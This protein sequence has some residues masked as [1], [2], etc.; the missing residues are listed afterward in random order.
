MSTAETAAHTL[1]SLPGISSQA[2]E[3]ST[4]LKSKVATTI[5]W[6]ARVVVDCR[7]R[8]QICISPSTSVYLLSPGYRVSSLPVVLSLP[9]QLSC[10]YAML[11]SYANILLRAYLLHL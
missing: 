3:C 1:G 9:V 2:S 8:V 10:R 7:R 11:H 5:L 4:N 6:C